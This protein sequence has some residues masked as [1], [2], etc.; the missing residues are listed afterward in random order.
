MS[1]I[2]HGSS[3]PIAAVDLGELDDLRL[4]GLIVVREHPDLDFKVANYTS[5]RQIKDAEWTPLLEACR[6]LIFNPDGEIIARPFRRM[7]EITAGQ[8]L[9]EGSF[10]A[11]E[12]LDGSLGV[13]YP[14][15][16]GPRIATRGNFLGRQALKGSELLQRYVGFDFGS[17]VT[18]LWEI[19]Y[20][21]N[22]IV[23]DYGKEERLTL[24]GLI[25]T[26]TGEDQPLPDPQDVPFEVVGSIEGVTNAQDLLAQAVLNAEGFVVKMNQTEERIK[27]KFP[28]YDYLAAQRRGTLSYRVWRDMNSG[29]SHEIDLS[30]V[31]PLAYE[32]VLSTAAD[33]KEKYAEMLERI[34]AAGIEKSPRDTLPKN[35]AQFLRANPNSTV[36]NDMIWQAIRPERNPSRTRKR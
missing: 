21:E 3:E 30:S 23:V 26:V 24:L 8:E 18:P 25:N 15:P 7:R 35:I 2:S 34:A 20:P 9:P 1:E 13:Q 27:V 11:Y 29:A 16:D 4:R 10:I 5:Q 6:G 36:P 14:T 28:H 32:V 33:L 31:P 12:K 19:I 17:G 22:K